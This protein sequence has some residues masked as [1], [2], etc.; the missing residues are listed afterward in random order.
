[1]NI[2]RPTDRRP[3]TLDLTAD[4]P[5][6]LTRLVKVE[7]RKMLDTRAGLWLMIAIV[8]LTAVITVIFYLRS[9]R[10]RATRSSTTWA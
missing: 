6:P 5:V 3:G 1:M 10:R 9:R 2:A 8:A 4:S 7:M